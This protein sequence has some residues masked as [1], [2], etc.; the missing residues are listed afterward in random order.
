MEGGYTFLF[1]NNI[2]LYEIGSIVLKANRSYYY[3]LLQYSEYQRLI[4]TI[5]Y[6]LLKA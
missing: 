4:L 2:L 1:H 5:L 3:I 6:F